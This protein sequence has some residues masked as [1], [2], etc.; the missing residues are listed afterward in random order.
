MKVFSLFATVLAFLILAVPATAYGA[1]INAAGAEKLKA[2]FEEILAPLRAVGKNQPFTYKLEG[3]ITIEPAGTYYAVTLPYI[4]VDTGIDVDPESGKSAVFN[5][6][7]VAVNAAPHDKPGEWKM[8]LAIPTP[9]ILRTQD[10]KE[11]FRLE[12]GR[13]EAAG[14]WNESLQSFAKLDSQYKDIKAFSTAAP[15]AL[16]IADMAFIYDLTKDEQDLWSGPTSVSAQNLV[17]NFN[18]PDN[19]EPLHSLQ[20]GNFT[21]QMEA[22]QYDPVVLKNFREKMLAFQESFNPDS[23]EVSAENMMAMNNLAFETLTTIANGFSVIYDMRDLTI[24]FPAESKDS[25]ENEGEDPA[26]E[27]AQFKLDKGYLGFKANGLREKSASLGWQLGHDG[28]EIRPDM[29]FADFEPAYSHFDIKIQSLPFEELTTLGKNTL[30]SA[31]SDT[32]T[33]QLAG[34]SLLMKIPAM[35]SNAGTQITL[36]NNRFGNKHW[37]FKTDAQVKADI[38]AVNSATA[39]IK[40]E[41]TGLDFLIEK[42]TQRA[43]DP[44]D[45]YQIFARRALDTLEQ[46]K[47][48]GRREQS[49]GETVY[50]YHIVMNPQGQILLNG[51]NAM[52]SLSE[53]PIP[54]LSVTP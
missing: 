53:S 38:S 16:S 33:L 4:S 26:I 21:I 37:S 30:Q 45:P 24:N 46:L 42:A 1:E 19:G 8:T 28:Y 23:P 50:H 39:D 17:M 40:S 34:L 43:S 11:L 52:E 2:V 13:Q 35:L 36:E 12:I 5:I 22:D 18:E 41:V 47:R 6:G 44:G 20:I 54:M 29:G 15:F 3:D 27:Q 14:I 32:A 25:P 31:A 10:G 9:M 7:R 48:F 49:G 51:E